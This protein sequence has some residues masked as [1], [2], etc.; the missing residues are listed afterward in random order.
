MSA[1][2]REVSGFEAL[3]PDDVKSE[4]EPETQAAELSD[5]GREWVKS[6]EGPSFATLSSWLTFGQCKIYMKFVLKYGG[7][8]LP[9]AYCK[10]YCGVVCFNYSLSCQSTDFE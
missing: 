10:Y 2:Y 8:P 4:R 1:K 9:N 6:S 5:Q 3:N 7:K